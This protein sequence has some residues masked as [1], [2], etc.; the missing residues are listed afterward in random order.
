MFFGDV[1]E[2]WLICPLCESV[3]ECVNTQDLQGLGL[4]AGDQ[5]PSAT[6][7]PADYVE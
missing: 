2:D 3:M 1:Y 7:P 4:S 6:Q 5:I